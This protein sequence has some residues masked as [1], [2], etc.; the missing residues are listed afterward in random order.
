MSARA[1]N[2][3]KNPHSTST[4]IGYRRMSGGCAVTPKKTT[5]GAGRPS[6]HFTKEP[7]VTSTTCAAVITII[8]S[9]G[10]QIIKL[11][12]R[13]AARHPTDMPR[14]HA[15]KT[16]FVKNVRCSAWVG[17]QRMAA[18][19]RK[20][21]KTLIR[22]SSNPARNRVSE[23][24][25]ALADG[26]LFT[27]PSFLNKF[28]AESKTMWKPSRNTELGGALICLCVLRPALRL[29]VKCFLCYR[30][31]HAKAPRLY[32]SRK[33]KLQLSSTRNQ[34]PKPFQRAHENN[35][36]QS[37]NQTSIDLINVVSFYPLRLSILFA[38]LREIWFAIAIG[39]RKRRQGMQKAQKD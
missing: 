11:C 39:S 24:A 30:I 22:N 7:L 5:C 10:V 37:I 38:A 33:E 1:I 28:F 4:G 36:K 19:S 3:K 6:S 18:N 8:K 26:L 35:L 17:N 34:K 15:S 20:R 32:W 29:C 21:I 9:A 2:M 23:P 27:N 16:T 13:L 12:L 14:K 31:F 25:K